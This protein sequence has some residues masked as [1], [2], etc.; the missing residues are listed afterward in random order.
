[1]PD[2]LFQWISACREKKTITLL[3]AS[4]IIIVISF[5]GGGA[6]GR[7]GIL[8]LFYSGIA[9]L[10]YALLHPWEEKNRSFYLI[11]MGTFFVLFVLLW[12]VGIDVLV[13]IFPHGERAADIAWSAGLIFIA[14]FLAGLVGLII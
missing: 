4:L 7:T 3:A 8:L 5:F 10:F 6:G 12:I 13:K 9:L 1:M 14:G 2:K 11:L